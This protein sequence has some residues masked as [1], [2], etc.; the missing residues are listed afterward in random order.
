[1]KKRSDHIFKTTLLKHF[2]DNFRKQ[3][4]KIAA[5]LENPR[6]NR[7]S[8]K[9]F[10][11][12]KGTREYRKTKDILHVKYILRHRNIN[13]TRVYTHLVDFGGEEEYISKIATDEEF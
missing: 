8:F 12:W 11:H 6:K 13:N 3:R 9:T 4:V 1:M 2:G 7:I 5:K 10:R